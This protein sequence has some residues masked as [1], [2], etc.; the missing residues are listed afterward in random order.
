MSAEKINLPEREVT[1]DDL[2]EALPVQYAKLI[3]EKLL[4]RKIEISRSQVRRVFSGRIK[5]PTIILPV[6]EEA[7]VLY[8]A[9][10]KADTLQQSVL[11]SLD[12]VSA[13]A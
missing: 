4:D 3:S 6:L 9:C 8:E 10:K 5:D 1:M 13:V 2:K 11:K 7:A 12:K